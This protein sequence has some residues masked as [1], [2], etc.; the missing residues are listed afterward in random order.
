MSF[1]RSLLLCSALTACSVPV[2]AP[3]ATQQVNGKFGAQI[4]QAETELDID[5]WSKYGD[6]SLVSLLQ[7]ARVN[8]PD[9]R[10]AAAQIVSARAQAGQSYAT[11]FP[12]VIGNAS[13][14]ISD[15][16]NTERT[17]TQSA[18]VDAS[19]EIDLFGKAANATR[20]S[21]FRA[22]AS[23]YDYVGAYVSLSAEVADGYVAYRACRALEAIDRRTVSSQRE[24]LNATSELVGAGLSAQPDLSLARANVASAE[25]S[26]RDQSTDCQVSALSLATLIGVPASQVQTILDQGNGLPPLTPFRV[27]SIT[28]D[29]LRQ[30]SDVASAEMSFAATL[31]DLDVAR[32]DLY[33]SLTLGGSVTLTDPSSWSLGPSLS[34]PIF[35]AGSRADAVRSS[36]A[37]A[38]K[39]AET[40]R[41]TVLTAVEEVES[42]LLRLNTARRNQASAQTMAA[43]YRNYFNSVDQDWQ[44]GGATLTDRETAR[45]QLQTAQQTEIAQRQAVIQQWIA[46]YKAAGGGW[47]RPATNNT[48]GA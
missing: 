36:N 32:A 2:I 19:W 11:E 10:S 21:V 48:N 22:R 46:L 1:A 31:R 16:E 37:D 29:V 24:T 23:E 9:L 5:W 18:L 12:S 25:I 17:K 33:P 47:D 45:R 42:A 44:A 35:D 38:I 15:G 39:S 27:S 4:P 14:S 20:A 30:R 28:T 41:S 8:S 26:L 7:L 43:E 3:D 13:A 34:L 6:A 40:Y